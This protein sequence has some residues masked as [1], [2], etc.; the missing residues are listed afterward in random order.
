M[1]LKF[2]KLERSMIVIVPRILEDWEK[3]GPRI[4][5]SL[6]GIEARR[7]IAFLSNSTSSCRPVWSI[8]I[9]SRAPPVFFFPFTTIPLLLLFGGEPPPPPP[10]PTPIGGGEPVGFFK[11]RNLGDVA[12]FFPINVSQTLSLSL[13]LALPGNPLLLLLSLIPLF[14]I[15]LAGISHMKLLLLFFLIYT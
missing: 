2:K 13:A 11:R 12:A 9:H 8:F 14:H 15:R 7:I 5:K 4:L 6:A 1:K 3:T 10:P